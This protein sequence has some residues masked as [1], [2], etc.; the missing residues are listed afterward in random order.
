QRPF[1]GVRL[2]GG[3]DPGGL[4]DDRCAHGWRLLSVEAGLVV[5][6]GGARSS[7]TTAVTAL[8][9]TPAGNGGSTRWITPAQRSRPRPASRAA[10]SMIGVLMGGGTSRWRL[11]WSWGTGR[12]A[13]R[14]GRR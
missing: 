3:E 14:G 12:R 8:S 1:I 9:G 7:C 10:S 13:A 4:V 6:D 11:G 2:G 5:G